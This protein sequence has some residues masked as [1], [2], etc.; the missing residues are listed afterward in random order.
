M[1]A[2]AFLVL[3]VILFAAPAVAQDPA[4]A[5]LAKAFDALR[6]RDYDAAIAF[7]DKAIALSP[8]RADIHQNLAY[9]LLKT[10]DS[11]LARDQ[12]GEAM[13]LD[14]ADFHAALE[15]AFLCYEARDNAPARK[16]E[17]RRI[18][19]RIRDTG[20]PASRATAFQA[21]RNIDES[22]ASGIA[23]WQ[24]VLATSTP[25]F[26]A[27]YELAQLAEQRDELDLA[28]ASYKAAFQ[29]LPE[30]KSVLLELA[31]VEKARSNP[32]NAMAA[33]VAASRGDEP[34]AAEL[35]RE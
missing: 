13:R 24:E 5:P 29:L 25:T 16:A 4:F 18:F 7:F 31:R 22:L 3:F 30:R 1:P 2:R 33:L 35:A 32:E 8:E 23:R 19:A 20:D 11:N 9:T 21:F 27:H 17:A 15:Y 28:A 10:G 34:R 12:F 26:G 14:A 6:L